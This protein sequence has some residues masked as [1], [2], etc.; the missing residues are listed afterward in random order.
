MVVGATIWLEFIDFFH[1]KFSEGRVGRCHE[2]EVF[3]NLYS[4]D[5]G[6]SEQGCIE[7]AKDCREISG[8]RSTIS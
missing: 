1:E 7:K 2:V 8:L 4:G 5:A 3:Q 6:G